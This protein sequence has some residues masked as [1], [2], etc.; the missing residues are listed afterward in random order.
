MIKEIF[1]HSLLDSI[2]LHM[3]PAWI[4]STIYENVGGREVYAKLQFGY[5]HL[6]IFL[7]EKYKYAY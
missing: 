2:S 3:L 4:V 1:I 5:L 6:H 7:C